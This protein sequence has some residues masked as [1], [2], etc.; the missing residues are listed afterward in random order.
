M[1]NKSNYNQTSSKTLQK[2]K[3]TKNLEPMPKEKK[4]KITPP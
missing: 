2:I 4:I 1:V 3:K